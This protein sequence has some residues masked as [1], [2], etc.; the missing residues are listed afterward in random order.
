MDLTTHGTIPQ[1][2]QTMASITTVTTVT[3]ISSSLATSDATIPIYSVASHPVAPVITAQ[4]SNT[5]SDESQCTLRYSQTSTDVSSHVQSTVQSN[6]NFTL[7]RVIMHVN[8]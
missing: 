6:Y 7:S 8:A 1:L 4:Y 2:V 3:K 5:S